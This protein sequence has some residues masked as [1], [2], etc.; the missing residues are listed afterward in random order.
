MATD[1]IG[2]LGGG[3]GINSTQLVKDLVAANKAPQQGRI[4]SKSDKFDAQLSAYGL[5]KSAMSE[6]QK[7]IAP[8]TDPA[9]FSAKSINV[10]TTDI[11]SFNSLTSVAPAGN[12]QLE[13][14]KIATAQSLAINSSQIDAD[15]ALGKTGKLT[16]KIGE[17]TYDGAA[18]PDVFTANPDVATFDIDITV[19]DTLASIAK[20]INAADSKVL[21]SVI[22]IDGQFQLLVTAESGSKNAL[23]ITTDNSTD[24]AGFE[25]SKTSHANVIETQVGQNAE[26]K[27]NGLNITRS[28]N[29]ISNVI[30]GLDFTLNKADL[31]NSISFSISQ[32]KT[33]AETAIKGLVEAYNIFQKTIKPLVGVS[34]NE[35]NNLVRGDL[36]SDG[37][38]KSLTSL[39][40][41]TLV[42]TVSGLKNTDAYSALGA[43]GIKTNTDGSL[44][45]NEEQ[46]DL[47]MKNDFDQLAG[48]FGVNTSSSSS[49]VELNTGSFAARAVAGEY[50]INITQ[51][52][53]KGS[54]SGSA[55]TSFDL[56]AG[57]NDFTINVNGTSSQRISL[58]NNYASIEALAADLQSKIN[59]DS[60]IKDAGFKV[61]VAVEAGALKITSELFGGTSNIQFSTVSSEFTAK[62]GLNTT[63]TGISG[64]DVKGTINGEEALG[65]SN[66]LLP[67]IGSNAY[68]LNISFKEDTP[69][70]DYKVNFTR[71]LAGEL[72]L[73]L[74]SS[75]AENGQIAKRETSIGDQK[76]V[77]NV[78]QENLDRKMSAYHA[79]LSRQFAAM[80]RIVASL[81]QTR[82]QL[83]GLIDRLPFTTKN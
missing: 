19:D 8:L 76:K 50:L 28:S 65:T 63:T 64:L 31:G 60:S 36:A 6:F 45:I 72:S 10:P 39:I 56:S 34:E 77:L 18:A 26:F 9:I 48:L 70:G 4:D 23:E 27:L 66:I 32:D 67:A 52:P 57:V 15:V 33:S 13:V 75:L 58:T 2:A 51:A 41:Q 5:L 14:S 80:E 74:S 68:G 22:N 44:S 54:I 16:F 1:I 17:W 71:G 69:L 7:I 29:D 12:Y 82:G 78:D 42:S 25:F 40:T 79:R 81:N 62:L 43:V 3:S 37:T 20:K 59:G 47:V 73:L 55:V 49:F 46:F 30:N 21:A 35:S 83:D 38:A 11:I 53:T 61:S 24:L